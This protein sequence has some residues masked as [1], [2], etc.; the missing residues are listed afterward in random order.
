ME[1][2]IGILLYMGVIASSDEYNAE[3]EQEY[4]TE[5]ERIQSDDELMEEEVD[6]HITQIDDREE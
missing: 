1:V 2:I 5:I 3:M 4:E 6:P